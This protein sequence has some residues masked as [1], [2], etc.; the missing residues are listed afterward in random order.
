MS[1][2]EEKPLIRGT[3]LQQSFEPVLDLPKR[4]EGSK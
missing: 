1:S 2:L 3:H 4:Q